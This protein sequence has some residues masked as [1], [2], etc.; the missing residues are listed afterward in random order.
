MFFF[1][2]QL[3]P[4]L[5]YGLTETIPSNVTSSVSLSDLNTSWIWR[6][7]T[8][9]RTVHGRQSLRGPSVSVITADTL[10]VRVLTHG[11][12]IYMLQ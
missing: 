1:Y 4:I 9:E 3:T 12:V 8:G 10:S 11:N 2:F 7:N 5:W 6:P